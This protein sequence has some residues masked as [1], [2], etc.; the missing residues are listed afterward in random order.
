LNV[1]CPNVASPE[2]EVEEIVAAARTATTKRLY[3]KLSPAVPDMGTLASAAARAGADGLSLVNTL[4][5][6]SLDERTLTPQ[7]ATATGGLSGPALRP[8]ALAAVFAA[9]AATDLPIVGMGGIENGHHALEFVAAGAHACA[10][11]TVLFADPY[12]PRRVRDELA[13][14]LAERGFATPVAARGVA[15]GADDGK[16]RAVA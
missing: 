9:S 13:A 3:A 5:G 14:E 8:V 7:L 15:R 16:L 11:G 2:D 1:S 10:L 4:R 12:A 6:L